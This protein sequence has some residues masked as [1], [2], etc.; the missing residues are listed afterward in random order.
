MKRIALASLFTLAI[1]V[2]AAQ[3]YGVDASTIPGQGPGATGH[4][5]GGGGAVI[6][7]GGDNAV[8]VYS[9][10]GAGG[11]GVWTQVPRIAALTNG[12]L[13]AGS[14]FTG[15]EYTEPER[16]RG[17]EAWIVGGGDNTEVLYAKPR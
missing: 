9:T 10:G 1:S 3:A 16:A 7:G 12:K 6:S 13:G 8:I 5:A 2:G 14:G 15:G 4:V 17:R 11:G